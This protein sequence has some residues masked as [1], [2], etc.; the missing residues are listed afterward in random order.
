MALD[1]IGA[2]YGRTGTL[3]LKAALER[4]GFGRCYHMLEVFQNPQHVP[5][6][7][8]A[9]QGEAVDWDA[10]FEEYRSAVDWPSC[11]LWREQW[12]HYPE[13]K[14]LLSV[15]DPES[16]YESV[17]KTI[18]PVSRNNR[19][20]EDPGAR[21]AGQWAMDIIWEPIFDDRMDDRAHVMGVFERHNEDVIASVPAD[22]LLVFEAADGWEPLCRFL[23]VDVPDEPYPRSNSSAEFNETIGK[24][25]SGSG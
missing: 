24:Q 10:L 19:D 21:A 8:R 18:Y 11:N 4:L 9:H 12:A 22:R 15:R 16:W 3:S 13:A 1:V 14:V 7:S 6:W 5:I 23:G 17:M 20:S 2:G 25:A